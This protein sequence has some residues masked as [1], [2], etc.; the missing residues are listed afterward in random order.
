MSF[1][2]AFIQASGIDEGMSYACDPTTSRCRPADP[3]E[4]QR[5]FNTEAECESYCRCSDGQFLTKWS[6]PCPLALHRSI[7]ASVNLSSPQRHQNYAS[8]NH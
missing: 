8:Q 1:R 3:G 5:L 6:T 7:Q 4:S 2:S